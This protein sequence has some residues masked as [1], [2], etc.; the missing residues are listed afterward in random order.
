M[1]KINNRNS[2]TDVKLCRPSVIVNFEHPC[3]PFSSISIVD[4]EQVIVCWDIIFTS[5]RNN[6][7]TNSN[8]LPIYMLYVNFI[9]DRFIFKSSK[10]VYLL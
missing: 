2:R 5:V 6:F 4:F 8:Y 10:A 1:F 3:H 7:V 9:V